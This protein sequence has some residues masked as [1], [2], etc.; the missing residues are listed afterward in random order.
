MPPLCPDC[1]WVL[2]KTELIRHIMYRCYGPAHGISGKLF[3]LKGDDPY[4]T[5]PELDENTL[6]ERDKTPT[7]SMN[8]IQPA[9]FHGCTLFNQETRECRKMIVEVER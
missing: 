7:C 8:H 9:C 6:T 1:G 2:T 5:A 3:K 4:F